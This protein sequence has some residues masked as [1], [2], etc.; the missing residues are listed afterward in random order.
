MS[1]GNWVPTKEAV[2]R[3]ERHS[4]DPRTLLLGL[5]RAGSVSA[6]AASIKQQGVVVERAPFLR[7][8]GQL[9]AR[10]WEA[11]SQEDWRAGI[12]GFVGPAPSELFGVGETL[13]WTATGVEINWA[14]VLRQVGPL[15]TAIEKNRAPSVKSSRPPPDDEILAMADK[16]K[17]N[18]T[19]GRTIA[20]EMRFE[21]GFENV[22]NETVRDLIKGRYSTGRP[23][24]D[25]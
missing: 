4:D 8:G 25:P 1:Q 10:F 7:E 14:E 20:K 24:K 5:L 3:L 18:G 13:H 15:P 22:P 19:N 11:V 2:T 6:S 16:M 17:A 12:F 21:P 9:A 23:K